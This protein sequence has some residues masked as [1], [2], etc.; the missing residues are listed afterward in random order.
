MCCALGAA[1]SPPLSF[2]MFVFWLMFGVEKQ[3][4]QDIYL[5]RNLSHEAFAFTAS[6]A[7]SVPVSVA[8][9]GGLYLS[10]PRAGSDAHTV[11]ARAFPCGVW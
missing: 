11:S 8:C 7:L 5:A 9:P 10:G 3:R 2:F 6:L 4:F 1:A